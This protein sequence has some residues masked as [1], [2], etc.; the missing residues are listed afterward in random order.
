VSVPSPATARGASTPCAPIKPRRLHRLL[1]ELC[2]KQL[3]CSV[4]LY[5]SQRTPLC[6]AAYSSMPCS[7]L[8]Y[9]SYARHCCE[10]AAHT[11]ALPASADMPPLPPPSPRQAHSQQLQR[12]AS[13]VRTLRAWGGSTSPWDD[14]CDACDACV[15]ATDIWPKAGN[16]SVESMWCRPV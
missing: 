4:L 8:L 7:V 6:L 10:A 2:W 14:A 13:Q 15:W 16:G 5:A 9:A 1:W 11:P 3:P 12:G